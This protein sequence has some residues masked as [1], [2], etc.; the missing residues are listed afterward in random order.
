MRRSGG[1]IGSLSLLLLTG[2]L[3][4]L[5]GGGLPPNIHTMAIST[6]DNQTSS[7]DVTKEL[8]DKMHEELQRKLGVRDAPAERADAVVRGVIQT[9]DA[10]VPVGFSANPQQALT[11][12]RHLAITIEVD[13]VD[14]SN[15]RTLF[16]N[17]ALR[18]E[19]DYNERAEA[20]GRKQAIEK[21]VQQIVDGVQSNW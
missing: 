3:Y 1:L 4:S 15:G 20:D 16:T 12:R 18:G 10:D 11:A 8:F 7:P 5:A 2:C 21:L 9:Y 17:K 14:Q 13:I 19:A 6:F